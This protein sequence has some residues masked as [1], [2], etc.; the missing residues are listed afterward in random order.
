MWTMVI[1]WCVCVNIVTGADADAIRTSY[2]RLAQKWYPEQNPRSDE[3][4]QVSASALISSSLYR[5]CCG[6]TRL[7]LKLLSVLCRVYM[8]LCRL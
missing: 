1:N 4:F 6:Q 7:L 5:C 2:K 3:T 8:V